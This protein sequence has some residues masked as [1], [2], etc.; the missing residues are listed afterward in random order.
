MP[1]GFNCGG[2]WNGK[3]GGFMVQNVPI[4]K[5]TP[6]FTVNASYGQG[7]GKAP[8]NP[9]VGVGFTWKF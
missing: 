9:R 1:G 5:P 8:S 7:V 6:N 2:G 4:Y 3:A